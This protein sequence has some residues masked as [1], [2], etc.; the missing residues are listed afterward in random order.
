M[1]PQEHMTG[2]LYHHSC[3]ES[4]NN[5]NM[6]LVSCR[7][8]QETKFR[9]ADTIKSNVQKIN[10][11]NGAW[12]WLCCKVLNKEGKTIPNWEGNHIQVYHLS[13]TKISKQ[14]LL[15]SCHIETAPKEF[16]KIILQIIYTQWDKTFVVVIVVSFQIM[17]FFCLRTFLWKN[18]A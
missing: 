8:I 4:W 13:N 6:I 3:S 2:I 16:H 11:T 12:N 17:G 1:D 15:N 18:T 14:D 9:D 10:P 7:I 5:H